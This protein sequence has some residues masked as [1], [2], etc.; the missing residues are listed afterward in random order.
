MK[1]KIAKTIKAYR[2]SLGVSQGGLGRRFGCSNKTVSTWETGKSLPPRKVIE[3]TLTWF[4][5]KN[6]EEK[7]LGGINAV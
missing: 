1:I 6:Y 4:I 7:E 2:D 5:N 3:E